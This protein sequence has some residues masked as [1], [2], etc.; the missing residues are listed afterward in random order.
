MVMLDGTEKEAHLIDEA[1]G[2]TV[3]T[4]TAPSPRSYRSIQTSK[5]S[6]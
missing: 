6:L 1:I 4:F 5:K 2:G 3:T